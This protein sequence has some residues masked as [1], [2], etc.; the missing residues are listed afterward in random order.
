MKPTFT[1]QS[2]HSNTR[3]KFIFT[4]AFLVFSLTIFSQNTISG[5]VVDEKGKPVSGANI[6]IEGTYDGASSS[7]TGNFSFTTTTTGNQTLVVSF[8]IYET[9]KTV[10]DVANFQNKTIKLRESVTSL[11]AVVITAG[12]LEAGDKARVSVLKPL[13]IVTTAGSAGNIIAALQTLPGTQTVGEDGRLFVRGGEANETQTFVDGIRVAQPYGATTNNLPTRGRFSPFLFSGISFSTGGYSAEYGEALSSVLLLNT[14]D[15]PDQNKTEIALMTVGLGI[16]NTQK[17]KKS[18]LSVNANY[19]NLAPYQAVI[20]QNVDWNSPFQSLSGETV[21]RYNFNNGI[22][23]VYA[24][25]DSSKFDIN[26]ENIN[27]PEKIRVDLNNNNFYLNSSYKGVFGNNWQ[28]TSGLSYGYSNNKINLDSDKVANDE[29]AAHLKLKLKKSFSERL[30]LSF[31]AD[32][33]VTQFNEDFKENTGSVFTNGYDANIAAVYTEADIFFSKKWAAKVGVRASNNDLLNETAISPRIS[34][35]YKM[36]KNSQFSF[37]YGDFTQTPNAEYIKYSNNHQ[38]ESEKA[39][40]YILNFQYNKN[41]KTFRAETYFKDYSNLV[42]F[43]TQMAAYNSVYDN[44]GSGYAK[45]LDLFWRDGKSIKN[46]EYWVSYSYIDTERNYKNFSSQ[47]TP[48]FV[49]DHSLSIVTKYWINDWKSQIGFTNSYSSGRPYNNPNEAKFM[50]GKTKSYNSLS[51][52]WAYLVSQQKILYF[53]VSNVLGS[54]NVFGYEY[55][56]NPDNTGFYNRKEIV[57]TAD[58]FFFIGFFWTI[59]NDKKDNQLKNL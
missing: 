29:N 20:P 46:L 24:A 50:N 3:F 18:S 35:A 9:S 49:A 59:S 56:N 32:Y 11:D 58:R 17:W 55:A 52:N 53:S 27:S 48:S 5:K 8:L 10:I 16:G 28:I 15:D 31:G 13:D 14:Q 37:A 7:E 30:K 40:H 45:G 36:A 54:Q 26:Q 2:N 43:D 44:S 12:T 21:Y 23:K 51:F 47:V 34:F 25:F 38:F 19:I 39:S 1:Q 41:G 42:K 22:L 57:P 33:F 6:F 4:F